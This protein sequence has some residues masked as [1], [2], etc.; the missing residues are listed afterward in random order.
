M[1]ITMPT[2]VF[3]VG[4]NEVF[5]VANDL[6]VGTFHLDADEVILGEVFFCG[7]VLDEH[8]RG[9][10]RGFGHCGGGEEGEGGSA[11]D[12]LLHSVIPLGL[13]PPFQ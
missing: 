1:P 12:E 13:W 9:G 10:G 11:A 8:A 3:T 4:D 7:L 2:T 6:A 5:D